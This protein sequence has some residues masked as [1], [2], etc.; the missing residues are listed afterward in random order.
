MVGQ[1]Y[2]Y[3]SV[4]IQYICKQLNKKIPRSVK[5]AD[6]DSRETNRK[7]LNPVVQNGYNLVAISCS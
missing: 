1:Q 5:V 2:I 3:K 6:V 4:G 7:W